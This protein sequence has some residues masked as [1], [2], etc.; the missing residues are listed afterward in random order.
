MYS[1]VNPG[2]ATMDRPHGTWVFSAE[3]LR[4]FITRLNI[5]PTQPYLQ[6][7]ALL[8]DMFG[9]MDHNSLGTMTPFLVLQ[10]DKW[11]NQM[12]PV[13]IRTTLVSEICSSFPL[14]WEMSHTDPHQTTNISQHLPPLMIIHV[15]SV[16]PFVHTRK[17]YHTQGIILGMTSKIFFGHTF[18]LSKYIKVQ[19]F[20]NLSWKSIIT[21]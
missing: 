1:W 15:N 19:V 11:F 21:F 5:L 10:H 7:T 17:N 8:Q 4:L 14:A 6:I 9:G 16:H 3:P 2:D 20:C 18:F 13:C 12:F